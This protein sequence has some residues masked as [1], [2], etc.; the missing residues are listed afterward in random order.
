M[1]QSPLNVG[2]SRAKR[3]LITGA[4]TGIGEA[5]AR[6]LAE[7]N[8]ILLL[9]TGTNE[10]KISAVAEA[11][12]G[13]TNNE[14]HC[15]TADFSKTA[16]VTQM[17]QMVRQ[18]VGHIDQLVLNAGYADKG[19]F[20]ELTNEKLRRALA[21][22]AETPAE[23]IKA[24]IGDIQK[25]SQ[26]RIVSISSFVNSSSGAND[27]A[28]TITAT[29]KSALEGLTIEAARQCRNTLATANIISPGY[30]RK[31]STKSALSKEQWAALQDSLP[32]RRL[33][34][35]E[36]VAALVSFLLSED[37]AMITGQNISIDGGFTLS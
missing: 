24:F 21:V 11:L 14:V 35:P 3:I 34:E 4:A 28:F 17:I 12:T 25:S 16:A 23:L 2:G 29:A 26:G 1:P 5:C 19:D 18:K 33:V 15:F 30:T 20:S 6:R 7:Q 32:T 8:N 27:V 10:Q 37:A 36:E 31:N 13:R 9:H 22:M